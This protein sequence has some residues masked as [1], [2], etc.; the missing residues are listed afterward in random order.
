M[1]KFIVS[2]PS[3]SLYGGLDVLSER[4]HRLR[5]IRDDI[6]A[7][8]RTRA[9]ERRQAEARQRETEE[10]AQRAEEARR[11]A[12]PTRSTHE[13]AAAFDDWHRRNLRGGSL[14]TQRF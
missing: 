12:G 3:S 10:Q 11:R 6:A 13:V 4:E 14:A 9:E 5:L 7:A 2:P 8:D 1:S